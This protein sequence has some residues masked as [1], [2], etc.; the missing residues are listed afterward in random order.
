MYRKGSFSSRPPWL[1]TLWRFFKQVFVPA[2]MALAYAFWEQHSLKPG[3]ASA[4]G[5]VKAFGTAFFFLMWF[6]GQ[7]FRTS[8][9]IA[10]ESTHTKLDELQAMV[11]RLGAVTEEPIQGP[12]NGETLG[13]VVRP[14]L[15]EP[16]A[17][18]HEE[19][20]KSTKGALLVVG[21]QIESELRK[22]LWATGWISG[23]GHPS[24]GKSVAHLVE[25]GVVAP[26][27]ASSVKAFLAIR[28]PLL[29][30]RGVP[31]SDVAKAVD[32]GLSILR[33]VIAVPVGKIKVRHP[34]VP[35]FADK[36]GKVE[37]PG[38]LALLLDAQFQETST[39]NLRVYPTRNRDYKVGQRLSHEW[40][41]DLVVGPSWYRDISTG[42][43]L[44]AWSES[45]E[46]VGRDL[47]LL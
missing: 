30:G 5:F 24:I 38:I 1:G 16:I 17:R 11:S 37:R 46:F 31:D 13:F 6:V 27:L 32:I 34:G 28:N 14:Q 18:V 8:K 21:A 36:E 42:E 29:H 35:V 41:A 3:D 44:P 15:E 9:Q 7:W 2:L 39:K 22:L 12:P 4:A 25:L 19:L 43:I 45:A 23:V 20:Q 10:D 47:N 40:N 33:A 26:N